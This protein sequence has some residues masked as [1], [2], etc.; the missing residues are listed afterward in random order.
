M[1][2]NK[3]RLILN[4]GREKYIFNYE[5]GQEDRL[6]DAIIEQAKDKRTDFDW[7]DA[8][9]LSLNLTQSLICQVDQVLSE[10]P[11]GAI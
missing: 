3:R 9:V 5:P 2:K 1:T 7:F 10:N 11:K 4:K 6:L 8:A